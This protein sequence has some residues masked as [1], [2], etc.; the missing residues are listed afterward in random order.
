MSKKYRP[1]NGEE[2]ECFREDFCYHCLRGIGQEDEACE[3]EISSLLYNTDNAGYP[4]ELQLDIDGYPVCT[5]FEEA[6]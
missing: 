2:G 1:A 6:E 3:I 5:A 4:E